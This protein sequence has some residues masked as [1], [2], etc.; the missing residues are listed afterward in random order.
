MTNHLDEIFSPQRLRSRW[1]QREEVGAKPA[2]APVDSQTVTEVFNRLKSLIQQR[3]ETQ[4]REALN[5]QLDE[6]QD[7]LLKRFSPAGDAEVLQ[8][9]RAAIDPAI[10][11]VL[12]DI[13]DLL[14]AFLL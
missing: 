1:Q 9:E 10:H 8:E 2:A 3:F 11:E 14:E 7:L 13:E 5:A 4:H 12:N 6:L